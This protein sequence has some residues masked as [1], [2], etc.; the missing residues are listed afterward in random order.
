MEYV[1]NV[2]NKEIDRFKG[3]NKVVLFWEYYKFKMASIIYS[4]YISFSQWW[5]GENVNDADL[6][7]AF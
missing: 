2:V 3:Q 5:Y 1:Y 4:Y 6:N 7:V